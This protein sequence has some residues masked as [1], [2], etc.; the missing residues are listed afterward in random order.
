MIMSEIEL[1]TA[2]IR[3]VNLNILHVPSSSA[4]APSHRGSHSWNPQVISRSVDEHHSTGY[5]ALTESHS[6]ALHDAPIATEI[7]DMEA[8]EEPVH[9]DSVHDAYETDWTGPLPTHCSTVIGDE[10]PDE[11]WQEQEF[12]EWWLYRRSD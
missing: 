2:R 9:E 5:G 8:G 10:A 4:S 11:A 6:L 3:H 1:A 7:Y 12:A